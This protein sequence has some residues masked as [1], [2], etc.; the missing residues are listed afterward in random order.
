MAK[1]NL[2]YMFSP[3]LYSEGMPQYHLT[4]LQT[5][6]FKRDR[7]EH[8]AFPLNHTISVAYRLKTSFFTVLIKTLWTKGM[9]HPLY[10]RPFGV[11]LPEIFV[12]GFCTC[13]NN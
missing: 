12:W 13:R 1:R 11:S 6:H 7:L 10:V 5:S 4:V 8:N 9:A 2:F 3:L